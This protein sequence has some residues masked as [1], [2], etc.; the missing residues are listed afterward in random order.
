MVFIY[1][2][3]HDY[4]VVFTKFGYFMYFLFDKFFGWF[5]QSGIL[6]SAFMI[7]YVTIYKG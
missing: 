2:D 4:I 5:V 7:F 6:V 1:L 3:E